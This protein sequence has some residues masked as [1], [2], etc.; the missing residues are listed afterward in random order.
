MK[1]RRATLPDIPFLVNQLRAFHATLPFANVEF[2]ENS[3]VEENVKALIENH[4]MLLAESEDGNGLGFIAGILNRNLLNPRVLV[5]SELFWW[6]KP[7]A[8]ALGTGVSLL[9]QFL[10]YGKLLPGVKIITVSLEKNSPVS[11]NTLIELGLSPAE[12]TFIMEL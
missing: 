2:P 9:T 7:E 12:R 1:I 6:V 3:Y 5:L 8:R 10:E 4:L 11:D